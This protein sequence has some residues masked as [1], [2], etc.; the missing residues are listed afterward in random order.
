MGPSAVIK[1]KGVRILVTSHATYDWADEQWQAVN[2]NPRSTRFAVAKNPMNFHNVYKDK[3]SQIHILDTPGPTPASVKK[4]PFK[5]LNHPCFPINEKI[6]KV[7]PT[8]LT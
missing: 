4:L 7:K 6:T 3:A 8:I 2:I 1:S 5:N